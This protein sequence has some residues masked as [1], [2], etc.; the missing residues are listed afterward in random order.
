MIPGGLFCENEDQR[1]T[2]ALPQGHADRP[3]ATRVGDDTV[4]EGGVAAGSTFVIP[5][6]ISNLG[7]GFDALSVAVQL[8]LR[9][10]VVEILPASPGLFTT[11]FLGAAPGGENRIEAAFRHAAARA[12]VQP[13]GV[14]IEI[15]SDIPPRAGL[16]SSG[17]ATIAGLR[18]FEALT[19]PLPQP[20]LLG[21]ACEIDGHPDNVAASLLGGLT[22]GCVQDDG[23]VRALA[24]PWPVAISFVVATPEAGLDTSRARAVLPDAV[25]LKDAVFNLQRALLF[26]RA[27]ET[28]AYEH[29]REALRDRWHQAGRAPLVP[30][31]DEALA[32]DAPEILGVCL[33]GSGPSILA[34]VTGADTIA[35]ERLG[36]IYRRLGLP[37]TIRTLSAHQPS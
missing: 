25:T 27:I 34:F 32:L 19:S 12:V 18:L 5:G 16:G 29:L 23:E 1:V 37:C 14:R 30:G 6:S 28:G 9:L 22:V 31:L 10:R 33:S 21:M 3:P 8:Y 15:S 24:A 11:E 7:P 13:P 4:T 20:R 17:A 2:W 36:S 26:V 35:V